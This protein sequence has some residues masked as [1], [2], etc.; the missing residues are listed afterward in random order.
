MNVESHFVSHYDRRVDLVR[1]ALLAQPGINPDTARNA[2]VAVLEALD[3][4]PEHVR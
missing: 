2:A 1:V 3:K 4:I